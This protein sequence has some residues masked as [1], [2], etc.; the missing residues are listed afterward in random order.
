MDALD[1]QTDNR[2][3]WVK[4]VLTFLFAAGV[5][6]FG[7][8]TQRHLT[9]Q[10]GVNRHLPR[11]LWVRQTLIV[12][13][14]VKTLIIQDTRVLLRIAMELALTR[15]PLEIVGL[16]DLPYFLRNAILK[17]FV[18][19][20]LKKLDIYMNFFYITILVIKTTIA[21]FV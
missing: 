14:V 21:E 11:Q 3:K 10:H 15:L 2:P 7:I 17:M 16:Y 5:A 6:K 20:L 9:L 8:V 1:K 19:Y 18:N 13:Q 12:G 4:N